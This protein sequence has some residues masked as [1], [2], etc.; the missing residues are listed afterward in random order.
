MQQSGASFLRHLMYLIDD[1]GAVILPVYAERQGV[2][3]ITG[4]EVR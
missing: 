1:E 3:K 2:E 4:H